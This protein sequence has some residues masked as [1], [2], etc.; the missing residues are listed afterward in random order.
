VREKTSKRSRAK[1]ADGLLIPYVAYAIARDGSRRR[2]P[3]AY[4]LVIDVG[5]SE[6]E[7]DLARPLR[8]AGIRIQVCGKRGVRLLVLG[9]GDGNSVWVDSVDLS[10]DR[11]KPKS[12]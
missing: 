11:W 7:I 1:P 8:L 5:P 2:V 3:D 4:K 10:G 6:L 9:P 12:R